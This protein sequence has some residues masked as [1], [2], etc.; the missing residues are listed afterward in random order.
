MSKIPMCNLSRRR[1][2]GSSIIKSLVDA[3][4][5]RPGA[6]IF[7]GKNPEISR[8]LISRHRK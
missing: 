6:F 7:A 8:W 5:L 4:L 1:H 2:I 3:Y